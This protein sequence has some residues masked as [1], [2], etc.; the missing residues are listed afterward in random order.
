MKRNRSGFDVA[1]ISAVAL[2]LFLVSWAIGI[3]VVA[4]INDHEDPAI[5]DN[6]Q[7]VLVSAIGALSTVAGASIGYQAGVNRPHEPEPDEFG[8]D[9]GTPT[10]WSP[11]GSTDTPAG[12]VDTPDDEVR[13]QDGD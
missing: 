1:W 10:G 3:A 5:S 2:G 13:R 9:A 7:L 11:E 6:T 4:V 12:E 8:E